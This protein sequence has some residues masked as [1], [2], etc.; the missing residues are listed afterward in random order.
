MPGTIDRKRPIDR[1]FTMRTSMDH[2]PL[3]ATRWSLVG[4]P[5]R[6]SPEDVRAIAGETAERVLLLG[7]TPE[8]ARLP[9]RELVAIDHAPAMIKH[10]L[11]R[12][13]P[14]VIGDWRTLPFAA[15]AFELAIGDGVLSNLVYPDE[16]ERF[17]RELARVAARA[18]LRVFASP[19]ISESLDDVARALDTGAVRSFHAL[20]WRIAMAVAGAGRN[21]AVA[22]IARAFDRI[23]PDRFALASRTGWARPVIDHVDIYRGS[24]LVYSFPTLDE[25]RAAVAP[26]FEV[27]RV[28]PHSYELGERC[29]TIFLSPS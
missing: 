17:A 19:P 2:W 7:V 21:V 27:T 13:R 6:P 16:Y 25:L 12:H 5:L 8:L 23:A 26:V 9:W 20:K 29:P 1:S 18:A 24:S 11:P 10:L 15:G 4:P 14:A 28:Q 22:D 3:H